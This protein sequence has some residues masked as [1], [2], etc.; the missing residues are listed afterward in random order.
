MFDFIFVFCVFNIDLVYRISL[1]INLKLKTKY[2]K[3]F[4]KPVFISK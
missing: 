4:N 1:C 3:Q 2:E